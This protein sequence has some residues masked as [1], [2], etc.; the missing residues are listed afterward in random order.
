MNRE[1]FIEQQRLIIKRETHKTRKLLEEE[2]F[3]IA[4]EC[5]IISK[6]FINQEN[7]DMGLAMTI[8]TRNK[9]HRIMDESLRALNNMDPNIDISRLKRL[10][11]IH[12]NQIKKMRGKEFY[13]E[14]K[15]FYEDLLYSI[16]YTIRLLKAFQ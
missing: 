5:K 3:Q 6:A 9:I 13:L 11:P 14:Q 2:R 4:D 10:I 7:D 12:I 15:T 1:E 8:S 16:E